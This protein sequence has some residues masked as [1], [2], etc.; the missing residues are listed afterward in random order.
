MNI[1]LIDR[2]L[3]SS[4]FSG[5]PVRFRYI[6]GQLAKEMNITYLRTAQAG[7]EN[8]SEELEEWARVTFKNCLRMPPLPK[9]VLINRLRTIVSLRPWYDLYGKYPDQLEDIFNELSRII[10]AHE[11]DLVVTFD[12]EV[13]QYGLLASRICPW[14]QDACDSMVLQVRRQAAKA[15]SF[16]K[17]SALWLRAVRETKLEREMTRLARETIYVAEDDATMYRSEKN[18]S[19]EVIPNGVDTDY[20]DPSCVNQ[21][22]SANPFVVFTGHMSFVPNQDAVCFFAKEILPVIRNFFPNLEFKIV[23]ADPTAKVYA[24]TKIKGVEVTG[25]VPDVRPYLAGARAFVCSMRMGSGIKN[26]LL[27]AMAMKLPIV[28]TSL[29]LKGIEDFPRDAVVQTD[30]IHAF[31]NTLTEVLNTRRQGDDLGEQARS[32]V[33]NGY[34]WERAL[35]RY[36]YLFESTVEVFSCK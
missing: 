32:F 27:E 13:A 15:S 21:I 7:E 14:I 17:K 18:I 31:A 28:A 35:I 24:L 25:R 20:F 4:V 23:G 26:K 19:V 12:S 5:K 9:P 16:S 30:G 22:K 36:R 10:Q 11:I 2:A 3:P 34:S 6:Y 1:L 33:Q 8:E 29:A